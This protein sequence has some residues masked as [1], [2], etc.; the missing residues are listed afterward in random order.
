MAPAVAVKVALAVPAA[1]DTVEGT[2]RPAVEL[3]ATAV[4]ADTGALMLTVQTAAAPD[5]RD[6]GVHESPLRKGVVPTELA[7]PPVIVAPTELLSNATA[8]APEAATVAEAAAGARVM[9]TSAIMPFAIR[10]VL[11]PLTIQ[12]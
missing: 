5:A 8:T 2:V 6:D 1:S 11:T 4:T 12:V 7:V 9:D 10:L 3:N